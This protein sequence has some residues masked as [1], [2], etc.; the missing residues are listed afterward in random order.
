MSQRAAAVIVCFG[1]IA[2]ALFSFISYNPV[3]Q[4]ARAQQIGPIYCSQMASAASGFTTK[5]AVLPV[6]GVASLKTFVCGWTVSALAASVV[7]FQYGT[8]TACATGSTAIGPTI[9]LGATSTYD[10]GS[11]VFRGFLVPAGQGLCATATAAA[12]ATV[13]YNLQ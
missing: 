8:G 6:P 10:D 7:T 3:I 5:A 2:A 11:S 4:E 1:V 12:N 13:Y 9:Q